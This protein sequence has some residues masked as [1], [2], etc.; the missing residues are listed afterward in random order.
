MLEKIIPNKKPYCTIKQQPQPKIKRVLGSYKD[1][2]MDFL[3]V[4]FWVSS[5]L[6]TILA[7][8]AIG[9]FVYFL[10]VSDSIIVGAL[11]ALGTHF[12]ILSVSDRISRFLTCLINGEEKIP[13]IHGFMSSDFF[14][15]E[16]DEENVMVLSINE[17]GKE[18]KDVHSY[19][20]EHQVFHV[21][22][23]KNSKKTP[24]LTY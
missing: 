19:M 7:V 22:L 17:N 18:K 3:T 8:P 4:G 14:T 12:A 13:D 24:K 16:T 10:T 21:A 2:R 15:F 9:V 11:L 23:N 5:M 1:I 20:L 6:A